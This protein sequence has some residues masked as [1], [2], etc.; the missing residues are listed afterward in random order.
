MA[1]LIILYGALAV[2]VAG[3]LVRILRIATMPAH[4]RW[5]LYPV[6]H[7]PPTKARYGGSY[8]EETDWWTKSMETS[9]SG[10]VRAVL[11]EVFFLKGVWRQNRQL[12]LWSWLF[13]AGLYFLILETVMVLASACAEHANVAGICRA[14]QPPLALVSWL[15]VLSGTAGSLGLL[16]RRTTSPK[17]RPFTSLWAYLNL[18]VILLM[19]GTGLLSLL[20][21]PT[22][23]NKMILLVGGL[24]AFNAPPSLQG[25]MAVHVLLLALFLA[26]FPFTHMTHM[27]MKYF[28]YHAVQWDDAPYRSDTGIHA[29]IARSL[30][31]PVSWA[32]PHIRGDGRKTWIEIAAEEGPVRAKRI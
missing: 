25:T 8:F 17:L 7:E 11:Q 20:V 18:S 3:N 2:F 30:S 19:F 31:Q 9:R 4:L 26:Y 27:Y 23:V 5:E 16:I 15:G 13:H 10:E 14:L 24:L 29:S 32:A 28:T 1:L 22:T 6:P 21:D 12:W